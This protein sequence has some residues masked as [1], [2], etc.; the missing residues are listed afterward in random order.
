MLA[1]VGTLWR[2]DDE[3][4]THTWNTYDEWDENLQECSE[5]HTF[6]S[7]R[8]VFRSQTFLYDI[9]VEAPVAKVGEPQR[10][11]DK[12]YARAVEIRV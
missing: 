6:L 10:A 3:E 11:E 1:K 8:E 2:V 5:N 9:L 7:L 12:D 4:C